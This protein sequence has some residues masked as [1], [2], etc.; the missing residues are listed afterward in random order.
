MTDSNQ[1]PALNSEPAKVDGSGQVV[2]LSKEEYEKLVVQKANLV[3]DK[4]NLINEVTELRKKNQLTSTEKEELANK[5]KTLYPNG[6]PA[7]PKPSEVKVVAERIVQ[8]IFEKQKSESVKKIQ[9]QAMQKFLNDSPEFKPEND[10]GG[11]KKSAW[12]RKL[13]RFNLSGLETEQEFL[14]AFKDAKELLGVKSQKVNDTVVEI[15]SM[16]ST[17]ATQQTPK[18]VKL[19]DKEQKLVDTYMGG[20]VA[21][22][23]KQ[24]EKRPDYVDELLKYVR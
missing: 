5:L 16:P 4:T 14:D 17:S 15:P 8:E 19:S 21:K 7:D 3:Q 13:E 23:L 24:K 12:V 2:T 9:N 10:E 18:T 11:L 1:N 20:D 6:E 22:F